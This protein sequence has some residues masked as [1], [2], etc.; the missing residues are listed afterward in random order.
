MPLPSTR[1]VWPKLE[2]SAVA[3]EAPPPPALEAAG[4]A[5]VLLLEPPPPHPAMA[6]APSA[7]AP[8]PI[9]TWPAT[10]IAAP[11]VTRVVVIARLGVR[12]LPGSAFKD[13]ALIRE[14]LFARGSQGEGF[15]VVQVAAHVSLSLL[16]VAGDQVLEEPHSHSSRLGLKAGDPLPEG[17]F[18][19]VGPK[20]VQ[21]SLHFVARVP[22]RRGEKAVG[23]RVVER[24]EVSD[25]GS[26]SL[27]LLL[28][29]T[30]PVG[31]QQSS[32]VAALPAAHFEG[33]RASRV[34]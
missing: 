7:T 20:R 10:F 4:A 31:L 13:G 11:F 18:R 16:Q 25:D 33:A 6:S 28:G 30:R 9:R 22:R 27:E 24:V 14:L 12:R 1:M 5:V 17:I 26:F 15:V 23:G 2:L 21:D 8:K 3:T 19:R 34:K 29:Q 32:Q